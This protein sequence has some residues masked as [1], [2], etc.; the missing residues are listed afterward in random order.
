MQDDFGR[1][2]GYFTAFLEKQDGAPT[3]DS[4][5]VEASAGK[6][7]SLENNLCHFFGTFL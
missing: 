5:V 4:L 3:L 2:L 1:I 6:V 7:D